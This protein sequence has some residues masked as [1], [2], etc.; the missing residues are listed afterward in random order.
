MASA[1][2]TLLGMYQWTE[3]TLF[4]DITVPE[5]IDK[6]LFVNTLLMEKG[7]L[8]TLWADPIFFKMC[9]NVW[10]AKWQ[11]T[12]SEWLRGVNAQY[13]PI[14]NYDRY[15]DTGVTKQGTFSSKTQA[16]Y[17]NDR[18]LNTEDK[19]TAGLTD[20]VSPA[21]TK[22]TT[23]NNVKD[24]HSFTNYKETDTYNTVK[25]TES[26]QNYKE[27]KTYQNV[28][29]THDQTVNGTTQHDVSGYDS[30][31]LVPSW[32]DTVNAGTTS[33]TRSGSEDYE[34]SGSH[35]NEKT[36]NMTHEIGGSSADERTG[37]TTE[38]MSGSDTTTHTGT[39]TIAHTGTDKLHTEGTLN[40]TLGGSNSTDTTTSHI[41]GNIGVTTNAQLLEGF[42]KI[43]AWNIYNQMA[44]TFSMELLVNVY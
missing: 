36:G 37:N 8:E 32:K 41:H 22:T 4:S 35:I 16:K 5:G 30:G 11:H 18:T 38:T 29:D 13:S 24:E 3:G 7:E 34:K 14:E 15:E 12:F 44:D 42:Y 21:S 26:F 40:D 25:D 17:D 39:D 28:K 9:I 31:T 20:T 10:A 23:Y 2:I 19:R 43:S 1:K 33:D 27:T 6:D